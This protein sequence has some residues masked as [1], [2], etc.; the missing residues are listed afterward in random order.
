MASEATL[1]DVIG[2]KYID[3]KTIEI[4]RHHFLIHH[5]P[6]SVQ[7]NRAIA[8]LFSIKLNPLTPNPRNF[9]DTFASFKF[10]ISQLL[11]DISEC[12]TCGS[13]GRQI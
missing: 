10:D 8:L 5:C 6:C 2:N 4:I 1:M 9:V 13:F 3:T 7:V 11:S 12:A